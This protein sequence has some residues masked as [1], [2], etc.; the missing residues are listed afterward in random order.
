[1]NRADTVQYDRVA[2][3]YNK[4]YS[5]FNKKLVN[6]FPFGDSD[7]DAEIKDL[8]E[9]VKAYEAIDATAINVLKR[10]KETKQVNSQ[11]FDF[12]ENTNKILPFLKACVAQSKSSDPNTCP[13][14]F[15][16][17]LRPF[18]NMEA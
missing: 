14:C 8:E 3:I 6:K 12:F 11:V 15:N 10:N 2:S 4:V 7:E 5:I 1:M 17:L 18:P 13:M 16:V 9:F